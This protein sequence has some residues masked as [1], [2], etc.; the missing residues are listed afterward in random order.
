VEAL[1]RRRTG[2]QF[3][4]ELALAAVGV[5]AMT[6]YVAIVRDVSERE[7]LERAR[8]Q[9]EER[10]RQ[11]DALRRTVFDLSP[12]ALL[13][14]DPEGTVVAANP[15]AQLMLQLH[16]GQPLEELRLADYIDGPGLI[17]LARL[18]GLRRGEE[19]AAAMLAA[20]AAGGVARQ[21]PCAV[22]RP[23]GD[24]LRVLF[25]VRAIEEPGAAPNGYV[26]IALDV[27]ERSRMEDRIRHMAHHDALTGL[28]NR[29][30]LEDRLERALRAAERDQ[31]QLAL[32]FV[33]LDRFKTIND[34][35]GHHAGDRLLRQVS[36]RLLQVV[37]SSDTVARLGGDEFVVLLPRL[38]QAQDAQQ[39][40]DKIREDMQRPFEVD[41]HE[42][43]ITPSIGVATYPDGGLDVDTLLRHADSAMYSAK[44][45]GR[46][47]VR[48]YT[49]A[50]A[51]IDDARVLRMESDL[52]RAQERGELRLALQP[53]FAAASGALVGAEALLRWERA[54]HGS[55]SPADFI[56]LAE[57]SGLIVSLGEWVLREACRQAAS[58]SRHGGAAVKIAVNLSPRQMQD[59][60]LAARVAD[61]LAA[62]GLPAS[63]LELEITEGAV[64]RDLQ[65]AA[66]LLDEL[67]R[68][69][70]RIA[71]DDFGVGFS[72][73]SYLQA[74]P[75]HRLKIDR[76]FLRHYTRDADDGR[77][78]GA[79]VS[80][81]HSMNLAVTAEGVENTAQ[82]RLLKAQRCDEVQGFLLGRPVTA[83]G[84]ADLL[85]CL[86]PAAPGRQ[87]PD[88]GLLTSR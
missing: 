44:A 64:V 28:P 34:S 61:A 72:S 8:V 24:L 5:S 30:L 83:D 52:H 9:A 76:S 74:L 68:H 75:V 46:N 40:A 23:D 53:Q 19:S 48:A 38:L 86:H 65:A 85:K 56:P 26:L 25:S 12:A 78:I 3:P 27:T 88:S 80:L 69:G 66:R 84:F 81:A 13:A 7:A 29:S 4:L 63:R 35:L 16:P 11:A 33:D 14:F 59:E 39:V 51:V 10:L 45:A 77:L 36:E 54:G 79:I 62:A 42:L 87:R 73:L 71:V 67:S 2:E 21:W 18:T 20:L 70:T 58:W 1:G 57:E 50:P 37:R 60:R 43:R 31:V 41:G 6:R 49:A 22:K 17:D 15:A 32:L 55:V 82:L 47:S